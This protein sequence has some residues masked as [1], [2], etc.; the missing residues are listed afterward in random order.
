MRP[1]IALTFF[2]SF[3]SCGERYLDNQVSFDGI[4]FGSSLKKISGDDLAFQVIV[5]NA[6]RSLEGAREAGRYE[7]TKYCI[8]KLSTS[9]ID[10]KISPD[11]D[12]LVLYSG[13]LE[14][15]GRCAL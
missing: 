2:L 6:A 3:A 1:I 9:D 15:S 7:A 13:N 10:W 11:A 8:E 5:R 4:R 14:L 12:D